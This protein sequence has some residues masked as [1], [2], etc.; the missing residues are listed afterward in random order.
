MVDGTMVVRVRRSQFDNRKHIIGRVT[1]ADGT[2]AG[3][4]V[5]IKSFQGEE[6]NRVDRSL[7]VY[8]RAGK[9]AADYLPGATYCICIDDARFVSNIIDLIPYEP[10]T[11][12]TNAPSLNVSPGQ[13]VEI[14][15]TAGPA[16]HPVAHQCINLETPHSYSYREDGQT[17]NGLGGRRWQVTTDEQGKAYTFALP[18]NEIKGS[19]YTPE[20]QSNESVQVKT[21]GGTRLE[22]HQKVA[23][24]RK[25][26]GRLLLA[27]KVDADLNEAVVQLGAVDGETNERLTIKAKPDGKFAFESQASRI[28]IY[29]RTKDAKA[30]AVSLIDRLD[31]PIELRLKPTGEF[32]GQLLG[33][34]DR[35]LRGHAVR[36][37]LSVGKPD[38]SKPVPTSFYAA[39]FESK[40]DSEGKYTLTGLPYEVTLISVPIR[41]MVRVKTITWANSTSSLTNLAPWTSVDYGRNQQRRLRSPNVT[42]KSYAIAA[43]HISTPWSFFFAHRM[44]RS[45]S[46]TSI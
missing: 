41:S 46:L 39:T 5:S 18:G 10:T 21:D 14:V 4:S 24:K 42:R 29:A 44:T 22:F 19:I 1:S 16:K 33:K 27:D 23:A 40:T 20:W 32:R 43:C 31:E 17:Q 11:D 2:V 25:I 13:P 38:Y 37:S 7:R 30:A 15:V 3:F 12:K 28:G 9:F 36:A 8:G 34:E 6:K 35:P 45:G 26:V